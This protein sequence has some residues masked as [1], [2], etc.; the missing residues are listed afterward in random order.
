MRVSPIG[1]SQNS[2]PNNSTDRNKQDLAFEANVTKR[3]CDSVRIRI[4]ESPLLAGKI[5]TLIK[6]VRKSKDGWI[7]DIKFNPNGEHHIRTYNEKDPAKSLSK[8]AFSDRSELEDSLLELISAKTETKT[9]LTE[10]KRQALYKELDEL[11]LTAE[12]NLA[13]EIMEIIEGGVQ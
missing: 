5:I 4:E 10:K 2:R 11:N 13:E 7:I 12:E 8:K 9:K 1:F 6:K 3:V